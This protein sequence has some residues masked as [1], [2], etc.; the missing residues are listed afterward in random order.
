MRPRRPLRPA[1]RAILI[2]CEGSETEPRYFEALVRALGLNATVDV[3]VHGDTGYTDPKGLVDEALA[4]AKRR[5]IEARKSPVLAPF[6]EV[7]VVFDIE[8]PGNGRAPAIAPAVSAALAKKL[9]PA[10]SKPSFEVWY[11]LHDRPTPP[12][13]GTG[14]ECVRQLRACAGGYAKDRDAARKI[15]EWALPRTS[16][17]L[18]YGHRQDV[19]T[20]SETATAFHIPSATGTAVHRLVQTLVHMSSDDIARARLGFPSPPSR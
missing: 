7:W 11:I 12:A 20:G 17:A 1:R 16:R 9:K 14:A 8:H 2:V 6:D 10:L 18:E 19:F 3:V 15:A 4:R 5:A 13:A